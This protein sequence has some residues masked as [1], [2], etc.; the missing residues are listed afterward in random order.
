MPASKL[1]PAQEVH[2]RIKEDSRTSRR[3]F[4]GGAAATVAATAVLRSEIA[5]AAPDQKLAAAPPPGFTPFAAPGRVVKVKK[6]D[7]MQAN[8]NYPKADDAKEM[9]RRA[10]QELTGKSD[11]KDAAGLFVHPSDKVCV[12]VNGIAG[13]RMGTN[14]ELVLPFVEAMIAAGVPA[15]NITI[16]EQ[17]GDF[18]RGTRISAQNVPRGVQV[19]THSNNDATMD[20]RR[21]RRPVSR[22]SS[23]ARSPSPPR[24]STSRSSKI[25]RF[26]ATPAASRT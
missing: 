23:C 9:L 24:S 14:K 16:L 19:V 18:L 10:L 12:K 8:G 20:S 17:F 3:L 13:D 22:R 1:S 7:C 4:L 2:R 5:L 26:A 25:I 15:Q 21:S 11:M 6:G